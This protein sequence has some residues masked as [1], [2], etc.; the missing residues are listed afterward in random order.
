MCWT[1]I[2]ILDSF[3]PFFK[4]LISFTGHAHW[5]FK[6]HWNIDTR[7]EL[8]M[9]WTGGAL[10]QVMLEQPARW[11]AGCAGVQVQSTFVL[12][13]SFLVCTPWKTKQRLFCL[14]VCCIKAQG[15]LSSW[16]REGLRRG[17]GTWASFPWPLGCAQGAKP[18][19][20]PPHLELG[21]AVWPGAVPQLTEPA[22]QP[23]W[24]CRAREDPWEA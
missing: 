15:S 19:S 6:R 10:E 16:W 17:L 3:F 12:P 2:N 23:L 18:G 1:A 20:S 9:S 13:N 24:V 7:I 8:L 11:I 4:N 21:R 14:I 22:W 5:C